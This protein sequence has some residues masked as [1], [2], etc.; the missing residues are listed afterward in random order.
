MS[1]VPLAFDPTYYLAQNEDVYNAGY[2]TD[3][4]AYQH[5][6]LYGRS[7]GRP[8]NVGNTAIPPTTH[9]FLRTLRYNVQDQLDSKVSSY[10]PVFSG[11]VT[12]LTKSMV[13]LSNVDNT[14]DVNK[15][16][17]TAQQAALD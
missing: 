10:N 16:V 3:L 8:G 12:G 1:G 17:S 11:T 13:G 15:P 5:W 2:N 9:S 6:V 14:S 7:E 4:L